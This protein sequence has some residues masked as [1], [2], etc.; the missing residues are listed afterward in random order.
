MCA[1]SSVRQYAARRG[2]T[3]RRRRRRRE[4]A[5]RFDILD[6]GGYQVVSGVS[7]TSA[8]IWLAGRLRLDPLSTV[9]NSFWPARTAARLIE[10]NAHTHRGKDGD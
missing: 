2:Y 6:L 10:A 1:E 4:E 8:R 9:A 7:L 3:L 5:P